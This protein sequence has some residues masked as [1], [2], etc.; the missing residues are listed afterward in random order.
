MKNWRKC[1]NWPDLIL[2]AV[3]SLMSLS[4]ADAQEPQVRIVDGV[5]EIVYSVSESPVIDPYEVEL[6][7]IFGTDQSE[8]T[9]FFT[10]PTPE[11]LT[12]DGIL[13]VVDARQTK[14]HWFGPDG[15]HLGMFGTKGDGPGEFPMALQDCIVDG[16]RIYINDPF[17]LRMNIFTLTGEYIESIPYSSTTV[18]SP[19]ITLYG[20]VDNR[21]YLIARPQQRRE[22]NEAQFRIVRHNEQLEAID[23]PVDIVTTI[24]TV[25][26]GR[27]DVNVPIFTNTLPD[28]ALE[29]DLPIAWSYGQEF[30]IDFLDPVDLSR[31]AV[32]IPHEALPVTRAL[33]EDAIQGYARYNSE[34]AARRNLRFADYLPHISF[35]G[36]GWDASGRLWVQEYRDRTIENSPFRFYVFSKDGNWLFRQ[37]LPKSPSLITSEGFYARGELDDGTP[38]V[39]FYAF[40]NKQ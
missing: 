23:T 1:F 30:R 5:R 3:I 10:L 17:A 31:W 26:L 32:T 14:L 40:A 25:Q 13:Y 6:N 28:C 20:P 16:E 15:T 35:L 12:D 39:E 29:I 18:S 34:E 27:S 19:Y 37:D 38:V 7:L 21:Q 36:R 4:I 11:V 33:R 8:D 24:E 9:Y 2:T 22:M